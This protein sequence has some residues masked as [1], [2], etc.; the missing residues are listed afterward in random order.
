[1]VIATGI[2]LAFLFALGDEGDAEQHKG[3]TA[4]PCYESK[5]RPLAFS[6]ED[7]SLERPAS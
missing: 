3:R 1:M 4:H 2:F 6:T 7:E 5:P